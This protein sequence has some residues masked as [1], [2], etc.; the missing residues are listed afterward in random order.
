MFKHILF[1]TDGST[2]SLRAAKSAIRFAKVHG[3]RITAFYA[4]PE[5]HPNIAG[6]YMPANFVTLSV[7]ETQ[8]KK[9]AEKYLAQVKKLATVGGVECVG[10]YASGDSPYQAIIKAANDAKCDLIFMASHGRSGI[11]GL[12]I[13]SETNK[14]LTHCKLP[15]LVYR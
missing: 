1:P 8:I 7:Y 9:A 4:A 14:V 5:Y 10:H 15:V 2:L 13:G 6:D 3:A 11:A 12:L